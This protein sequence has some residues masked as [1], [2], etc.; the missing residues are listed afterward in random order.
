VIKTKVNNKHIELKFDLAWGKGQTHLIKPLSFDLS[1]EKS[2][3]D[4]SATNYGYLN[5]LADYA[6]E[7]KY[8]FDLIVAKPQNRDLHKSYDNA[9]GLLDLATAPKRIVTEKE[10]SGYT[11]ETIAA[12][13][14]EK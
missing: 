11:D 12:L 7:R 5:L 4:K 1:E 10:L 9:L 14:N 2:I 6:R 13:L 3:Q 8:Q